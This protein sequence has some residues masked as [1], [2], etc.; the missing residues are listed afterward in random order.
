M[1]GRRRSGERIGHDRPRGPL[2]RVTV[3]RTFA[4]GNPASMAAFWIVI[5]AMFG[6]L[7]GMVAYFRKRGWL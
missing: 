6:I 5:G 7:L 2:P 4:S 1:R 3:S